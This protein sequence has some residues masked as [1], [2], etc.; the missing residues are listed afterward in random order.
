MRL[1]KHAYDMGT[2]FHNGEFALLKDEIHR[3]FYSVELLSPRTFSRRLKFFLR[4]PAG[5]F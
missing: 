4:E 1:S 5:F 2:W 3:I